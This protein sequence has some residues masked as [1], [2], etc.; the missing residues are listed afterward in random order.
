MAPRTAPAVAASISQIAKYPR[1]LFVPERKR[2][3][4]HDHAS[5]YATDEMAQVSA[6][7]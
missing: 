3:S 5:S 1:L 2:G 7:F 4:G 6:Y